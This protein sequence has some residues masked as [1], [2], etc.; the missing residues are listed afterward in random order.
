VER[1]I[2]ILKP[3]GALGLVIPNRLFINKSAEPLRQVLTTQCR[4][5]VIIDFGSTKLFDADAYV[6]CI[7]AQKMTASAIRAPVRVVKVRSLEPDF[8]TS[9]LLEAEAQDVG[10]ESQL[11]SYDARQPGAGPWQ[12][13][14]VREQRAQSLLGEASVQ[15][16]DIATVVQ[17][18][19]TGANDIFVLEVLVH[20]LRQKVQ[21]RFRQCLSL[22]N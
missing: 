18:I 13:L 2:Q 1:A 3:G 11:V 6:G 5:E 14:S 17:G 4:M 8:M 7:V 15:L 9:E 12:L 20:R 21:R 16:G 10:P 22:A 19:R